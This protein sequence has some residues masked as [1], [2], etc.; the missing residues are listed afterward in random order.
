MASEKLK[1]YPLSQ[2]SWPWSK[3]RSWQNGSKRGFLKLECACC[4]NLIQTLSCGSLDKA[5]NKV[6]KVLISYW[7]ERDHR[8]WSL[9]VFPFPWLC[10]ST[11]SL[12]SLK[13]RLCILQRVE[14]GSWLT[15][16]VLSWVPLQKALWKTATIYH[17]F[18]Y[19]KTWGL[20]F[21][22]SGICFC[23]LIHSF[24]PLILW[25]GSLSICLRV[26]WLL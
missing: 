12:P 10:V 8:I 14:V 4:T 5:P 7:Q 18:S 3:G 17:L 15:P 22:G 16:R 24:F 2:S 20:R 6:K 23:R 21:L 26:L 25:I 9:F 13:I 1:I 19:S 11:I